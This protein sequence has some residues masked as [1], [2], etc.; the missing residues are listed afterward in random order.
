MSDPR[1]FASPGAVAAIF[2]A[3]GSALLV[4][5]VY[6]LAGLGWAL[7]AGAAPCLALGVVIARGADVPALNMG[8]D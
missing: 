2:L 5:G 3:V 7:L 1:L 4:A 6:A 8:P